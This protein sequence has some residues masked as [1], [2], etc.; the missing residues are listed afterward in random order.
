MRLSEPIRESKMSKSIGRSRAIAERNFRHGE[1]SRGNK[2]P[3]YLIWAA[4]R[5]RCADK[6]YKDY[7]YYGGRWR[8]VEAVSEIF[9]N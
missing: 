1:A 8:T 3:E 9:Q 7:P 2:T 4:M 5:R 6:N